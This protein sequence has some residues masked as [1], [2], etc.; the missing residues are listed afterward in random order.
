MI[1]RLSHS[2]PRYDVQYSCT[3]PQYWQYI[4]ALSL[5]IYDEEMYVPEY[6][7]QKIYSG[8]SLSLSRYKVKIF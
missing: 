7:T 2:L 5:A 6:L 3:E 8:I 1:W 4:R